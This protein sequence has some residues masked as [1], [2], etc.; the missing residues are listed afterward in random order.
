M[1]PSDFPFVASLADSENPNDQQIWLR[2]ACD[3]FVAGAP[4]EPC[5]SA[6]FADAVSRQLDRADLTTV[7]E[8]AQKL[9]PCPRTPAR[10]LAKIAAISPRAS[11]YVLEHGAALTSAD[12]VRAIESGVRQAIAVA[13]RPNLDAKLIGALLAGDQIE[14]LTALAAN[15][16]ASLEGAVL[17][18][19]LQRAGRW[20]K[21]EATGGSPSRCCSAAR[22]LPRAPSCSSSPTRFSAW[23]SCSPRSGQ[24][25]AGPL[26]VRHRSAARSWMNLSKPRS[27]GVPR[28]S[29]MF[30]P[31]RSNVKPRL[32]SASSTTRRAN[33]SPSPWPP[34]ARPGTCSCAF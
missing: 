14:V 24:S 18:S 2:V 15:P 25:S 5:A 33:R 34:W 7:L 22:C 16:R 10:L 32:R 9:A 20:P 28:S 27:P 30:S 26:V 12:L 11:D 8:T 6:R 1:T 13:K 29:S 23:R 4:G 21:M 17:A 19:L 31:K 3:H